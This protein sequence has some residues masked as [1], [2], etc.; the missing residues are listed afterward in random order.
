[1]A[2]KFI[3]FFKGIQHFSKNLSEIYQNTDK[4]N[5]WAI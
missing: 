3:E 5:E 4:Y 1:M 2:D